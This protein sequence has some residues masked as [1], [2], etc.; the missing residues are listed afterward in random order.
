MFPAP[1]WGQYV[2][3]LCFWTRT[4]TWPPVCGVALPMLMA[5][6]L[7]QYSDDVL[8]WHQTGSQQRAWTWESKELCPTQIFASGSRPPEI[9]DQYVTCTLKVSV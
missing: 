4:T 3:V 5:D 9:T 1:L 7:C 2:L 6:V 8:V